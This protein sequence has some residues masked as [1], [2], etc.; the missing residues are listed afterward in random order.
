MDIYLWCPCPEFDIDV[1]VTT[2]DDTIGYLAI[3]NDTR[4][5]S[6]HD[7]FVYG[8]GRTI[9]HFFKNLSLKVPPF[10]RCID[11]ILSITNYKSTSERKYRVSN[12]RY[13]R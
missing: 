4:S 2:Y 10:I 9:R 7:S 11:K 8:T 1:D 13:E 12:F 3:S 6:V 5:V